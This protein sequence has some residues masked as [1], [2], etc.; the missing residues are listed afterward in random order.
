MARY[1]Y[2]R[3]DTVE[4]VR[5]TDGIA[6]SRRPSRP[7]CLPTRSTRILNEFLMSAWTFDDGDWQEF[8]PFPGAEDVDFPE[9][10]GTQTCYYTIHSEPYTIP[11]L[12]DKGIRQCY[13]K[14]ALPKAFEQKLRFLCDLGVA[15]TEAVKVK[16]TSVVPRD[17]MLEL[18]GAFARWSGAGK[19]RRSSTITRSCASMCVAPRTVRCRTGGSRRSCTSTRHGTCPAAAS[20]SAFP[21]RSLRVLLGRGVIRR[22]RRVRWR[23][24][25]SARGLLHRTQQSGASCPHAKTRLLKPTSDEPCMT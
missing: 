15:D 13:F 7:L 2:L 4:W 5:I 21:L 9:P 22:A 10:V 17:V 14:L 12:S 11:R 3:L 20:R 8:A 25:H 1:A 16:G 19:S 24:V 23:S 18:G 6:N